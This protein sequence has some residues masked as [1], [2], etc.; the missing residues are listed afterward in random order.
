MHKSY[1][2]NHSA[3]NTPPFLQTLS[4]EN[5]GGNEE[6]DGDEE[7]RQE[8]INGRV[9]NAELCAL[10]KEMHLYPEA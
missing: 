8:T 9:T 7:Y 3:V 6:S 4:L 1:N 10:S 5:F 2:Y